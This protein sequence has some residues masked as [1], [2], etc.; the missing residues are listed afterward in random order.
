MEP[1][2]VANIAVLTEEVI[3]DSSPSAEAIVRDALR[4]ALVA[5][6]DIDFIDPAK[7]A[8]AGVSPA[9]ITNGST[10]DIASSGTDADAIRLDVRSVFA[11]FIVASNAPS[12]GVWIMSATNALALSM[13]VNPLGQPEFSGISMNGGTFQGLPVIVSE[14]AGAVI[15]LVNANDIYLADEGG[16]AID[17]SR[18]ASLQMDTAPT[19]NSTTPTPIATVSMFQTN[20]VA[21]RAE[22]TINWARRRPTSVAYLTGAA[23]GGAVTAPTV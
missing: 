15:I 19:M 5:R 21:F 23:Y 18:E 7:A 16:I 10:D 12:S 13:M 9:S 17:L 8:V 3:R 20:S 11:R 1:L 14:Y 4:D 2:K 6:L 22:R